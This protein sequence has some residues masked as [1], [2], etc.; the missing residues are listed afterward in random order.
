ML[1]VK[2]YMDMKLFKILNEVFLLLLYSIYLIH[3]IFSHQG[4]LD[5]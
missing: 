3:I 5:R 1:T 4:K 2:Q